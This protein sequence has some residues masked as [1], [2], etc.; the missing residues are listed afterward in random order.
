MLQSL[1]Q[2]RWRTTHRPASPFAKPSSGPQLLEHAEPKEPGAKPYDP[3]AEVDQ[4]NPAREPTP[5][6]EDYA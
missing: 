2:S 4:L 5:E 6:P 1:L 3:F